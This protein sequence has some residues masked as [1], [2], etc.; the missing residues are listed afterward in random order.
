MNVAEENPKPSDGLL[1]LLGRNRAIS[2]PKPVEGEAL[3]VVPIPRPEIKVHEPE[4]SVQVRE[5]TP[6]GT[7]P[8][9]GDVKRKRRAAHRSS[10]SDYKKRPA[11]R[12]RSEANTSALQTL[13]R[14][15]N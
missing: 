2:P 6:F 10:P 12:V 13:M 5:T 3:N 9:K 4:P 15:S 7:A 8:G 1:H 14:T 11:P